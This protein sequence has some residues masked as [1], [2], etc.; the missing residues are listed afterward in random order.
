M[1]PQEHAACKQHAWLGR[2]ECYLASVKHMHACD[3]GPFANLIWSAA[4]HLQ[5]LVRT[6]RADAA[7]ILLPASAKGCQK[8]SVT[9]ANNFCLPAT[10]RCCRRPRR[11]VGHE[12]SDASQAAG[13][14]H[15]RHAWCTASSSV[16]QLDTELSP[17][18]PVS[19]ISPTQPRLQ[20]CRLEP[21]LCKTR[22]NATSAHK[23]LSPCRPDPELRK[24]LSVALNKLGDL[25]YLRQNLPAARDSYCEALAVRRAA[26][27]EAETCSHG[28]AALAERHVDVALSLAKVADIEKV[29]S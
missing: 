12:P 2:V 20:S 26:L 3:R 23:T 9:S 14:C 28:E 22:L 21:E 29:S 8:M 25:Q 19:V 27:R 5:K 6:W 18:L 7:C 15:R 24:T 1:L 17:T 11:A 16:C 13:G 4:T 10:K